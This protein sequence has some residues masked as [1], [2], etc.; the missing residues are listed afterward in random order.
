MAFLNI[1]GISNGCLD[2]ALKAEATA[3][4]S[5]HYD[6]RGR[7]P[8]VNKTSE[9]LI[10]RVKA[11]IEL[12]PQ[13]KSHYYRMDNPETSR[14]PTNIYFISIIPE[15][16]HEVSSRVYGWSRENS[17]GDSCDLDA[18]E[19]SLISLCDSPVLSGGSALPLHRAAL[20]I[21]KAK[22]E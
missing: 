13:Y 8:P 12:F 2:H 1:F 19:E 5:P 18:P 14:M 9:E 10:S 20:F 21:L 11:H 16:H 7:H 17:L 15:T 22:E 4:G 3:G 6:Q